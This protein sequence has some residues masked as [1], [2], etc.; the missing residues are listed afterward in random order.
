MGHTFIAGKQYMW[1]FE[2]MGA[3]NIA[4]CVVFLVESENGAIWCAFDVLAT[5]NRRRV[6]SSV[7]R[8]WKRKPTSVWCLSAF[9]FS[10]SK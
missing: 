9:L 3:Q 8:I 7:K 2:E 1:I 10:V 4:K 5:L 6:G